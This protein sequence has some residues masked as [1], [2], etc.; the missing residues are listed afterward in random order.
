M[1][2]TGL[3]RR[4]LSLSIL[5]ATAAC[6]DAPRTV[7]VLAPDEP[8]S[9]LWQVTATATSD[10]CGLLRDVPG[11]TSP[12]TP[13][14]DFLDIRPEGSSLTVTNAIHCS[15]FCPW[16]TGTVAGDVVTISSHRTGA[17]EAP[18]TLE[19]HEA[20]VGTLEADMITGEFAITATPMAGC[21]FVNPC[22][23]D[24]TFTARRCG[25]EPCLFLDCFR[26]CPS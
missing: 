5:L 6:S 20:D 7:H 15:N 16:G 12:F 3:M 14:G 1:L 4:L 2:P 11:E 22:T 18:C 23:I 10:S 26:V 8:V 19:I 13:L 24:G 21:Q 25:P 17:R 9:G